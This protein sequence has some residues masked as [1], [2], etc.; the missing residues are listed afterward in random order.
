MK[1]DEVAQVYAHCKNASFKV[2]INQLKRFERITLDLQ[3]KAKQYHSKFLHQNFHFTAPRTNDLKIQLGQWE[4]Q[5]GSSSKDIR[6]KSN[7][8]IQ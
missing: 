7:I 6:L 8:T 2:P 4:I 3:E 1:G 5:V